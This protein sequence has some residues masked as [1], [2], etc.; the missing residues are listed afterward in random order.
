MSCKLFIVHKVKEFKI[1]IRCFVHV[2][3]YVHTGMSET[4]TVHKY[5]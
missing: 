4:K 1:L 3:E 5:P 2:L